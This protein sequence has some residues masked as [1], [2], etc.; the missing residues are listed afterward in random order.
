MPFSNE[1]ICGLKK[2]HH[3]YL[4]LPGQAEMPAF[5]RMGSG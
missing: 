2:R 4:Y 3:M 1:Y 5:H